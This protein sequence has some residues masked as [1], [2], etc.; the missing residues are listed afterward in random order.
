MFSH[1]ILLFINHNLTKYPVHTSITELSDSNYRFYY[2]FVIIIIKTVHTNFSECLTDSNDTLKL[3]Q[4]I[5]IL[6]GEPDL[7]IPD[8]EEYYQMFLRPCKYYP[9]SAFRLVSQNI[10]C[11]E[12]LLLTLLINLTLKYNLTLK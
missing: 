8:E 9:E 10:S 2:C 7:N 11:M 1:I 6:L 4:L 3:C 5:F 12:I